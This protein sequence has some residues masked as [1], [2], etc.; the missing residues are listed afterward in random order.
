M[1]SSGLLVNGYEGIVYA[2]DHNCKVVNCSWGGDNGGQFGQDAINYAT[3]NKNCLVIAAAGNYSNNK[4]FYPAA[5]DNVLC[6]AATDVNDVKWSNS[7]Y[8]IYVDACAPGKDIVSTW[9]GNVYVPSSGTSMA[10]PAASGCAA[11]VASY[12]PNYSALQ[13]AERVKNTCDNIDTNGTNSQFINQL[14]HGRMNLYRALTDTELPAIVTTAKQFT[15]GN[16]NAFVSDDTIRIKCNFKNY[17]AA[18][19]NLKA[20]LRTNSA[21]VTIIDSIVNLGALANL[22]DTSNFNIPFKLLINNNCPQNEE[23]MFTIYFEDGS[24]NANESFYIRLNLNY[25]NLL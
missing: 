24:Y 13:I 17:L 15:D 12:F 23:A 7:N 11:I 5:Y 9:P 8:G 2:A 22:G 14:G 16:D 10:C 1:N 19:I 4:L 21:Y 3:F 18:T 6:I 20:K 25:I